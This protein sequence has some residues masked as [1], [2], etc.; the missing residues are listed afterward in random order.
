MTFAFAGNGSETAL[1]AMGG[2]VV[3]DLILKSGTGYLFAQP[4]VSIPGLVGENWKALSAL[5]DKTWHVSHGGT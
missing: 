5:T 4:D 2:L 3:S 1:R